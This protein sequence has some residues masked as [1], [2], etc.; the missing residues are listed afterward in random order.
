MITKIVLNLKDDLGIRISYEVGEIVSDGA[1]I[2]FI[3]SRN[4]EW[5]FVIFSDDRPVV[6]IP[7]HSV[8]FIRSKE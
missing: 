5:F 6:A 8:A 7:L 2:K 3:E 4:W 1:T